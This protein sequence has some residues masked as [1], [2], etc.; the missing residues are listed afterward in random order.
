MDTIAFFHA[1]FLC[2]INKEGD[3]FRGYL[4]IPRTHKLFN[5]SHGDIGITDLDYSGTL[6]DSWYIRIS[7]INK[8]EIELK[9]NRLAEMLG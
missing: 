1:N 3:L 9:L 7:G 5:V 2:V 8:D 4:E 6:D